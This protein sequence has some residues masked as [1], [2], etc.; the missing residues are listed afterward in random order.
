MFQSMR[1]EHRPRLPTPIIALAG[2]LAA[3]L[4]APSAHGQVCGVLPNGAVVIAD[5]TMQCTAFVPLVLQPG[6]P[7]MTTPIG[8]FT[9]QIGPFTTQTGPFTTQ[10]G[11]FTT[12]MGPF[13]TQTSP[14]TTQ[15][16]PP[17]TQTG[18]ATTGMRA[19]GHR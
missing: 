6:Q 12:Q 2:F 9:T 1:L 16:S 10:T 3:G 11:P 18:P 7:M 15:T 8:P 14:F 17:T 5:S 13:T 4:W 19:S